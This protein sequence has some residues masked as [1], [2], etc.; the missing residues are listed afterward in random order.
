MV[1]KK[2]VNGQNGQ[3]TNDRRSFHH[4]AWRK[5][6]A[7]ISKARRSVPH[8]QYNLHRPEVGCHHFLEMFLFT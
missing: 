1:E 4:D 2:C 6:A 3:G 5:V 7:S 8:L